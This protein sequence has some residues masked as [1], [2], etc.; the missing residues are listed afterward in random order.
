MIIIVNIIVTIITI[1]LVQLHIF[2]YN[3]LRSRL[4]GNWVVTLWILW[5]TS[6]MQW[7]AAVL[8]WTC[9]LC[10]VGRVVHTL[11]EGEVV[12]GVTSLAGE[13]YVLRPKERDE[14]E[15]YD[16]ITYRLQRC[17]TVP[18]SRSFADMTS[19]KHYCCM[20]RILYQYD[21]D[22]GDDDVDNDNHRKIKKWI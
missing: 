17:L 11:N 4:A 21:G 18:N 20:Y 16:V 19:C 15:V 8:R 10:T 6:I 7:T 14:V 22:N 1:I 9:C 2:Y 12:C 13:I 3:C 5:L